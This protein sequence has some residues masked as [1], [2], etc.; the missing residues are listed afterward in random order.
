MA[1][2]L[3]T[4]HL[5]EMIPGFRNPNAIE[6]SVTMNPSE[7]FSDGNGGFLDH[8]DI[9]VTDSKSKIIGDVV[10]E[11]TST[12]LRIRMPQSFIDGMK[13]CREYVIDLEAENYRLREENEA[14]K[15]KLDAAEKAK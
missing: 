8:E 2:Q 1:K 13:E 5:D 15:A 3:D 7:N 12:T 9:V 6:R 4:V 10:C 14:P 11:N